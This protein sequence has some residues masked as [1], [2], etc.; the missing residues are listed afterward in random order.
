MQRKSF[1]CHNVSGPDRGTFGGVRDLLPVVRFF[2]QWLNAVCS[3]HYLYLNP[4]RRQSR[5]WRPAAIGR[6]IP[7]P[8]WPAA[9]TPYVRRAQFN[10]AL[11]GSNWV[12]AG[13]RRT[14]LRAGAF[15]WRRRPAATTA[16]TP[17]RNETA[18]SSGRNFFGR[19]PRLV[20]CQPGTCSRAVTVLSRSARWICGGCVGRLPPGSISSRALAVRFL[21][22]DRTGSRQHHYREPAARRRF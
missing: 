19:V 3:V 13:M 4:A 12:T 15:R 11:D 2:I 20:G 10:A 8:S 21:T 1:H 18:P 17:I 14:R 6:D 7:V 5:A 9:R 22:P 16:S